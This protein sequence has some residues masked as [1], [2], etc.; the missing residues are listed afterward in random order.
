MHKENRFNSY[1]LKD[2]GTFPN[3][4]LPLVLFPGA[5][6]G[7]EELVRTIEV[8]FRQNSWAGSWRN[9]VYEFHHYHSTAHEVLG[10]YHGS[11]TVQFGGEQ[12]V[13]VEV[14][15]GDVVVIPAGVAHKNLGARQDFA[16]VGAYPDDQRPD[17]QRGKPGERP[18]A[19]DRIARVAPRMQD[20]VHGPDGPLLRLW[21]G[22]RCTATTPRNHLPKQRGDS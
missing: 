19:D 18:K 11:A 17:M 15:A 2:D 4:R 12:G 1:V 3:S 20:P 14:R 10:V 13:T 7:G 22:E 5:F 16:V 8:A 21:R 9:G 6:A